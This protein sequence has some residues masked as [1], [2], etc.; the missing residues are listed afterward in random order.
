MNLVSAK[1]IATFI[2][3]ATVILV[4]VALLFLPGPGIAIIVGGLAILATEFIWAKRWLRRLQRDAVNMSSKIV[5][6]ETLKKALGED[7]VENS[8][9]EID[10]EAGKSGAVTGGHEGEVPEPACGTSQSEQ[11]EPDSPTETNGKLAERFPET[12][13]PGRPS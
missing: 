5:S 3:G 12:T 13:A 8:K 10:T 7:F 6:E 9:R 11:E 1:R 4:G 2:M